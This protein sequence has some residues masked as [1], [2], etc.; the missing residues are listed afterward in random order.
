[1]RARSASGQAA[2][3]YLAVV[4]LVALV[5]VLVGGLVL[6]GRAIATATVAQ[7]RRGLCIVEGHDCADPHEPCSVSSHGSGNDLHV[8]V[9]VVRLGGGSFALIDRRS[10]G[11]VAVT[12][13]DHLDAGASV[14]LGGGL[15]IG[16][17]IAIGG[18]LRAA[19]L[20]NLGHGA[21]YEVS[22]ERQAAALLRLLHRPN[23]D[24]NFYT[25]AVRAY[26]RRVQAVLPR[27]PAPVSRYRQIEG[28]GSLSAEVFGVA[29]AG[30]E[31]V[32]Q[33]TGKRTYYL[34]ASLSLDA[35]D[36]ADASAKG[37][38]AVTLDRE[39]RP[40][41]LA[42][43]A[44]GELNESVDLPIALQSVAGH[45]TAGRGRTWE[46][47]GHLDLTQPGRPSVRSLLS[48]PS[49]LLQMVLD[50][51]SV[52]ARSYGTSHGSLG[53]EGHLASGLK[54][55]GGFTHTTSS[56]RLLTAMDHTREGFWVPRYDCLDAT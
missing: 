44:A 37:R 26:W 56:Q 2:V 23:V 19:A 32:D 55:G 46:L 4:A 1:M 51:G 52:Q 17:R 8:D 18:E 25:P 33:V 36:V 15:K 54:L 49:R 43:L 45:L 35:G 47:E 48:H 50:E 6:N 28:R 13:T 7:I 9:A 16:N 21:T 3:E 40:V 24:P 41:D 42:V 30:G 39:G 29:A 34:E 53:L 5:F 11:K 10:D 22:N 31:R 20:A 27:I 12:V 38:V 14:G